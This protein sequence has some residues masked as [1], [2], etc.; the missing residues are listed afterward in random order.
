MSHP[1]PTHP[2]QVDFLP[3]PLGGGIYLMPCPGRQG[4]DSAG[5]MWARDLRQDLR[6]LAVHDLAGVM[7]LLTDH[8]MQ[9][10]RVTSLPQEVAEQGWRWWH[11]P[12]PDRGVADADTQAL[13]RQALPDLQAIWRAGKS[14]GLHCAAGLGRTGMVA[15][16]FL[17]AQG[18]SPS[19][20]IATV[21]QVRPGSIETAEQEQAVAQ[22][23][24]IT[25]SVLG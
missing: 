2:F 9:T 15:A 8:D 18:L 22:C 25:S 6:S 10:Y 5:T 1:D 17:V 20:A 21:R 7:T 24:W 14:V 4:R 3:C 12:V 16:Q 19:T 11:W 13:M 23:E